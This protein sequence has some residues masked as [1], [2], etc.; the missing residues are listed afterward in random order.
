MNSRLNAIILLL[1][2]GWIPSLASAQNKTY[3]NLEHG[4]SMDLPAGWKSV[5]LTNKDSGTIRGIVSIRNFVNSPK[6]MPRITV[7]CGQNW[8][9]L[10]AGGEKILNNGVAVV[11]GMNMAW[12]TT[13]R[14]NGVT[15]SKQ[16]YLRRDQQTYRIAYITGSKSLYEKRLPEFESMIQSLSW[17]SARKIN[18]GP[19]G[20]L[21]QEKQI[22]ESI[23]NRLDKKDPK[24]S[25]TIN[26][27]ARWKLEK[28]NDTTVTKQEIANATD[29]LIKEIYSLR[30]DPS[31]LAS[32]RKSAEL[33][34]SL[35]SA[36]TIGI[37][38]GLP[39][40]LRERDLLEKELKREDISKIGGH[41]FY[42]PQVTPNQQVA[43]QLKSMLSR[44]TSFSVR[45]SVP[46]VCGEFHPDF[47]VAWKSGDRERFV[48][49]CFGCSEAMFIA[50]DQKQ[51]YKIGKIE[52]ELKKILKTFSGKRPQR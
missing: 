12:F 34:K 2:F 43:N 41:W 32:V 8:L 7:Q 36:M 45:S 51:Q 9:E 22:I 10:I 15:F 50:D 42:K 37:Y 1:F 21:T 4:F 27:M 20:K 14:K 24:L 19:A 48:L 30:Q 33:R 47:A 26:Q 40:Q 6:E 44:T 23:I 11:N 16:Y 17:F 18:E 28:S 38:E 13:Q 39:H 49:L 35:R 5:D 46:T 3:E 31:G 29:Q 25:N 52:K